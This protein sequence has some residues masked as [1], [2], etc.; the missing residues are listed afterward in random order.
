MATATFAITSIKQGVTA[1]GKRQVDATVTVDATNRDYVTSGL[2]FSTVQTNDAVPTSLLGKLGFKQIDAAFDHKS[3]N[4]N[5][6]YTQA[7]WTTAQGTTYNSFLDVTTPKQP[8]LLVFVAG[9][10]VAGAAALATTFSVRLRL[11]GS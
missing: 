10:Q 8:K 6:P 3:A 2:D 7:Q 1:S 5:E 4:V 9:A 11:Q